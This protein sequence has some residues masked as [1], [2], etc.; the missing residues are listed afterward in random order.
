MA[1]SVNTNEQALS[2]LRILNGTNASLATTQN[3]INTGLEVAGAQD[4]AAIFSI[5]QR[6][7]ADVAGLSAVSNSL[8]NALSAID[9]GLA[10]G[11]AA[12][13]LLIELQ[14][15]AVASADA[16]LDTA[17]RE[18]LQ[19]NFAQLR[20]QIG[21]IVATAE[22]NG[23]NV[24]NGD[25]NIS[26]ITDPE[27]TVANRISITGANLSLGGTVITI[28][29]T[30]SISTN[31]AAGQ[32]QVTAIND[33]IDNLNEVLSRFG[34]GATRLELQSNFTQS[35]SDTIEVGIGNLVDADLASASAD[36]Q[37]LQVQQQLGLQALSIAN[38]APS[39][40]LSLF[41]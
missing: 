3:Q 11:E 23:L 26:A 14:E 10:A 21:S 39:A 5:A 19:D 6:L 16:G 17:S 18:S 9:V 31:A 4:N 36:L 25:D 12:S 28:A 40:V 1:F 34:A 22:F 13:D 30:A 7:R 37:S 24:V 35:L 27:A 29:A 20:D 38:Q 15:L 41:G 32:A 2:A 33:S 8:D